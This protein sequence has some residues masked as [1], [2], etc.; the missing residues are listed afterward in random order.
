MIS[1]GGQMYSFKLAL[2]KENYD[3]RQSAYIL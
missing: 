1:E 2:V 3:G